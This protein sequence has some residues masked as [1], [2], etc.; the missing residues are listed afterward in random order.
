M[1]LETKYFGVIS[2]T[3]INEQTTDG[4][5]FGDIIQDADNLIDVYNNREQA[6][7]RFLGYMTNRPDA[8]KVSQVKAL[9]SR[10]SEHGKPS[11]RTRVKYDI[12][13]NVAIEGFEAI[14]QWT[15]FSEIIGNTAP[16]IR[17]FIA[18]I[19][20]ENAQ[21]RGTMLWQ[22]FFSKTSRVVVD[23]I[24]NLAVTQKPFWNNDGS[25]PPPVGAKTFASSHNHYLWTATTGAI[26]SADVN[27][28]I[29]H[30]TEHGF[31]NKVYVIANE[32]TMDTLIGGA[33]A[34]DVA[35]I[36]EMSE[37]IPRDAVN[38]NQP[39]A[40]ITSNSDVPGTGGLFKVVGVFKGKAGLAVNEDIPD[41]YYGVFSHEGFNSVMNPL[42]IREPQNPSLRGLRP[43]N[44]AVE[45]LVNQTFE[46]HF[47]VGTRQRGN[48]VAVQWNSHSGAYAN[49]TWT[50]DY[51]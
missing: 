42:Q 20:E 19:V 12:A 3:F 51:F 6:I 47:G 15:R 45:P 46:D 27:A 31:R 14:L 40:L 1:A 29:R 5:L 41:N 35:Q 28:H 30:V 37:W 11:V 36:Y 10:F 26:V 43:R 7:A 8:D 39:G 18:A 49:P 33:T 38:A 23:E 17:G 2:S 44:F 34:G 16:A 25:T 9:W 13:V 21:F 22:Q 4:V 32:T 24:T 48:G 50:E